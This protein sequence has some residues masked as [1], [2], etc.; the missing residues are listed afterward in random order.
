MVQ[1]ILYIQNAYILVCFLILV[2]FVDMH[3]GPM[4]S[5]LETQNNK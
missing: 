2:S 1:M 4:T 5:E 3:V